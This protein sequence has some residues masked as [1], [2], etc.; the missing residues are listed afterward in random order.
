MIT[1]ASTEC[2]APGDV[3]RI[4]INSLDN[5]A[6]WDALLLNLFYRGGNGAICPRLQSQEASRGVTWSLAQSS[7]GPPAACR[8]QG[9]APGGSAEPAIQEQQ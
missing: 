8:P 4:C 2:Y 9:W 3:P 1:A 7:H 6:L 5:T